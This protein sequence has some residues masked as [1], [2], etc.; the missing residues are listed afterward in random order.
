[1]RKRRG[2]RAVVVGVVAGGAALAAI[3]LAVA[4][5]ARGAPPQTGPL[6]VRARAGGP[7]ESF[8]R[9][10]GLYD[11]R[12]VRAPLAAEVSGALMGPLSPVAVSS[13]DG[14]SIAYST[15][16]ALRDVDPQHSFSKQ[17]I[18]DGEPLGVPSLRIHDAARDLLLERGAYSVA[19]RDDG[20][21]AYFKGSDPRFRAN[22]PYVG[23]IFVRPGVH[24]RAMKWTNATGRYVVYGWAR[25]RLLFYRLGPGEA[26]ELLVADAP[27]RARP[28]VEGS[29]IAL[30]PDGRRVAVA[31]PDGTNVRVLDVGTGREQAGLDVTTTSPG[32]RWVGYSGSWA[33]DHVVA[34]ASAGLAVFRVDSSSIELEQALSLDQ[35]DFPAGAQ[36]P[37][38][39]G[40][41]DERVVATAD[42]PPK[43]GFGGL[44]FFLDCDRVARTCDR[45][46]PT[47]ATEWPRLVT[48]PSRPEGDR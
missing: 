28:L 43:E 24:G 7:V 47:P 6:L 8:V 42:V 13:P 33:R 31:S 11:D 21:L 38:F 5:G 40:G 18:G 39:V 16:Q 37:R 23:D 14:A 17:G 44:S 30:S 34:P 29:A 32:L 41:S 1:M 36:E 4:F 45:S 27:G 3:A 12:G 48:N 35:G 46:A 20:A 9:G 22:R 19:W 25:D 26:L 15:W 2:G 10:N